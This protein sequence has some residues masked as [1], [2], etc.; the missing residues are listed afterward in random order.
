MIYTICLSL[1]SLSMIT[2]RSIH[3][4]GNIS[5]LWL[6]FHC[7]YYI[8][9]V[10]LNQSS[11][12]GHLGCSHVLAIVNNAAVTIEVRVS[13]ELVFCLFWLYA[14]S[15]IARSHGSSIFVL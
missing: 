2:S 13:F 7:I 8:H 10:F 14:Q 9:N 11:A 1:F 12:G 6:I 15:G 4:N 5:F 3:G